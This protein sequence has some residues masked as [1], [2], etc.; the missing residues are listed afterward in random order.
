VRTFVILLGNCGGR[1]NT[2]QE[3]DKYIFE[4]LEGK[5]TSLKC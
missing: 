4:D 3:A 5:K 1:F 2:D